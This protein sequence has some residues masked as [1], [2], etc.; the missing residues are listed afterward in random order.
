M[1]RMKNSSTAQRPFPALLGI[2]LVV[3]VIVLPACRTT[4]ALTSLLPGGETTT[5]ESTHATPNAPS[6]RRG[7]TQALGVSTSKPVVGDALPAMPRDCG[8]MGACPAPLPYMAGG[9]WAP[10][11]LKGP[12]PRDEYLHD[13][14]DAEE[15]VAVSPEWRVQGLN[16]EDTVAHYDLPDGKTLVTESNCAYVYA[17]RFSS[18]RT[19]TNVVAG[20]LTEGPVRASKPEAVARMADNAQ[21][22]TKTEQLVPLGRIGNFKPGNFQG[23]VNT[24]VTS[25]AVLPAAAIQTFLPFENLSVIRSGAMQGSEKAR[26]AEAS[27][28]AIVWTKNDGVK[29]LIGGQKAAIHTSDSKAQVIYRIDEPTNGRLRICKVASTPAAQPGDFVDFTIRYDNV[30]DTM[31]GNI[32]I[33]DSLTARLEYVADSALSSRKA[34]FSSRENAAESLEL[35]WEIDEPLEPGDGGI[36]KF[37][38]RVR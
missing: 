28:S 10:P 38:C 4:E 16:I 23:N 3:G 6:G 35:R 34:Q 25:Y 36:V 11:G 17:P 32:V 22:G 14:G 20:E 1:Q 27:E 31:I 7:S 30:G 37:R 13:G 9:T 8:P 33:L 5:E 2:G 21:V 12:F 15:P 18:V 19:V 29:V 26:L 24:A